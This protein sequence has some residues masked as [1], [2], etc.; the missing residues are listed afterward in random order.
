MKKKGFVTWIV[1]ALPALGALVA[2]PAHA[3]VPDLV[4]RF[5]PFLPICDSGRPTNAAAV[6]EPATLALLAA[7]FIAVGFVAWRRNKKK[8]I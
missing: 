1:T 4:C 2:A 5:L 3:D 7:A 8:H 6:P